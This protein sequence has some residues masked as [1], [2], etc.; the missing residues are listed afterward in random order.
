MTELNQSNTK[1]EIKGIIFD[2]DGILLD[3]E[4]ILFQ[5]EKE[6][7]KK[8]SPNEKVTISDKNRSKYIGISASHACEYLIKKFSLPFEVNNLV[9]L[10]RNLFRERESNCKQMKG[11]QRLV[12][13]LAKCG[14]PLALATSSTKV[15]MRIKFTRHRRL[16]EYF[17]DNV[18]CREDVKQ[19]KPNPEVFLLAAEKIGIDPKNCIIFEDSIT[20]LKA[21]KES[22][23]IAIHVP[24][25]EAQKKH[26]ICVN[27]TLSSLLDFVPEKYGIKPFPTEME[28]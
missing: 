23:A 3:T 15:D 18:C 22:G 16:R 27:E 28:N 24:Q 8:F 10:R 6:I 2:V 7:V 26:Q 17:G 12:S 9:L 19:A 5:V 13:H 1:R 20:G 14:Y 4:T 21:A 25:E 11:A